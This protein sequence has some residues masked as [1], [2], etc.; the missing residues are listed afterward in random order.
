MNINQFC[1]PVDG[2]ASRYPGIRSPFCIGRWMYASDRRI[3]VRIPA[4]ARVIPVGAVPK[5]NLLFKNFRAAKCTEPWPGDKVVE[6]DR[7]ECGRLVIP[8]AMKIGNRKVDT[9]YWFVVWQLGEVQYNP[10][11]NPEDPVQFVAGDLQG[12]LQSIARP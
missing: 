10:A 2:I 1:L 4:T 5:A 3:C 8:P 7:D 9:G 12:L 11:G 6:M